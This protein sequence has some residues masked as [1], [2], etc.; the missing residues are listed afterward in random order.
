[1]H[2]FA[3]QLS[4]FQPVI[5]GHVSRIRYEL[6]VQAMHALGI[7]TVL[8]EHFGLS[9]FVLKVNRRAVEALST[10]PVG[11]FAYSFFFLFFLLFLFSD[12]DT[13]KALAARWMIATCR[14]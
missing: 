12:A 13:I 7:R 10:R 9:F 3:F 8:A 6:L 5:E 4:L 14:D 2:S 1:M 11:A